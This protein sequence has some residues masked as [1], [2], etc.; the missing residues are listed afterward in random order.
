MDNS[1][2][3]NRTE[4]FNAY[5]SLRNRGPDRSEF[6]E[7]SEFVKIF[8]GFHR[9]AIMDKT[10]KGDQ[11]FVLERE[12]RTIYCLCNGEIYEHSLLQQKYNLQVKSKSDCEV[13]P[14]IYEQFGI[15]TLVNDIKGGEFACVIFDIYHK[16]EKLILH[17]I[18]DPLGIRPMFIGEDD[19]GIAFSSE[20]KGL[21][22]IISNKS[23]IRQLPSGSYL[24][25]TVEKIN[26]AIQYNSSITSYY[27]TSF[28]I[29]RSPLNDAELFSPENLNKVF[30]KVRNTFIQCVESMMESDRELGALLS[31]GLDSSLV[32]SVASRYLKKFG[33]KLHTFSIG[34]PGA[35]DKYYAEMVA[36]HC[37]TIH[38]HVELTTQ[39]FLNALNDVIYCIE[40]PDITT[41]RASTGQY[42][43]SKIISEKFGV[44]VLL[45]GDG[46]DELC[47]GYLYFHK[48]KSADDSHHENAK[49]LRELM[50]YD[51]LRADRGVAGN[52]LEARVPFLKH[53][54]VDL[55]MSLDPRLRVPIDGMEKWLLRKSFDG[56]DYLPQEVLFRRKEAFSDGVS[57]VADSWY[58]IIQ[59]TADKLIS[60][61]EYEA[62]KYKYATIWNFVPPTKEALYFLRIFCDKFS[63][64]LLHVVPHYWL[65]NSDWVGNITEPSARVLSNYK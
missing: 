30:E 36:K 61:S 58:R 14:L 21:S 18:R 38:T 46:S 24:T 47:S 11:P 55:I 7:L 29:V 49:L 3:F 22:N 52:G 4:L 31:G 63:S 16:E 65:P 45:I 6:H 13:I 62:E 60:D 43:I 54:F 15:D 1:P 8:I 26:N 53:T 64:D 51:V 50:Y 35:T 42:L 39:D 57:S 41:I 59:T 10:T 37:D 2:S 27:D 40:T 9:L 12:N 32:V 33:R 20:L 48:A 44:K 19:T 23:S 34:M 5:S 56:L 28:P 17:C 25:Y